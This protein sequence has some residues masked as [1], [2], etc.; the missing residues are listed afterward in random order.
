MQQV[1]RLPGTDIGKADAG[2]TKGRSKQ[3]KFEY[4]ICSPKHNLESPCLHSG[5]ASDRTETNKTANFP[6]IPQ[7]V[8]Q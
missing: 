3:F 4:P 6:P 8:W 1:D 5:A 2:H 7:V